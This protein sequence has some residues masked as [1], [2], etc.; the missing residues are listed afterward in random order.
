MTRKRSISNSLTSGSLRNPEAASVPRHSCH[1][2]HVEPGNLAHPSPRES[3]RVSVRRPAPEAD[4]THKGVRRCGQQRARSPGSAGAVHGGEASMRSSA[5]GNE[6]PLPLDRYPLPRSSSLDEVRQLYSNTATPTRLEVPR[7][8]RFQCRLN[9]AAVGPV[10]ISTIWSRSSVVGV[11]ETPLS[12]YF[13]GYASA[14]RS[15]HVDRRRSSVVVANQSGVC[16][17]PSMAPTARLQAGYRGVQVKIERT[18]MEGALAALL[19]VPSRAPLI[20]DTSFSVTSG[21]G[22]DAVR[23]L[24]FLIAELDQGSAWLRTPIVANRWLEGFLF[25]ML[26]AHP[27][28]HSEQLHARPVAAE[29]RHLRQVADH[30]SSC[31]RSASSMHASASSAAPVTRHRASRWW[32]WSAASDTSGASASTTARVS[33]RARRKR[34]AAPSATSSRRR[35][36]PQIEIARARSAPGNQANRGRL[37][38]R[39]IETATLDG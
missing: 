38:A 18:A 10:T 15:E 11:A 17:S 7:R 3:N 6:V 22:A 28:S 19:C 2:L 32:R 26:L 36:S 31:A 30:W 29:P 27:N 23:F 1:P 35:P 25:H 13:L 24:D 5:S 33:G 12:S 8:A 9:Y 4:K 37:C 16:A 14:G 39:R 34:G 21:Y 20:L